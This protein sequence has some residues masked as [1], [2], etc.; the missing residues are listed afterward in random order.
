MSDAHERSEPASQRRLT[1]A[2]DEGRW[3]QSA[4]VASCLVLTLGAIPVL[5]AMRSSVGWIALW[6]EAARLAALSAR[7]ES[8]NQLLDLARAAF[9]GWSGWL[10]LFAAALAAIG[11]SFVASATSGALGFTVA[12][13]RPQLSRISWS[14]GIRQLVNA[15][16]VAHSVT[17]LVGIAL[18]LWCALPAVETLERLAAGHMSLG[19]IV[20]QLGRVI[21]ALWWRF[22]I[23][24]GALGALDLWRVRRRAFAALRMTPR[25]VRDE[26]AELEGK[27]E[28]RARRRAEGLRRARNVQVSAIRSATAVLA[29]PNHVAV[30]LRYAPPRVDV[31]IVVS[32][33]ADLAA[34]LVRAVA[35]AH[36]V[37]IVESPELARALF[38]RVSIGEPIPEDCFAAVAAVFAW[39][40]QTRGVL[41]GAGDT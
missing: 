9:G 23:A 35:V 32:R 1:R 7:H 8:V 6:R 19:V 26:R 14:E 33:G 41:R 39:L 2:R 15:D 13:L 27:P 37:P 38:V 36:D 29:N 18:M 31:P 21:V 17:A 28:V 24:F 10:I 11:S 34:V 25:E 40:L 22:V 12:M 16:A 30:A 20:Q 3:P 4:L 5:L